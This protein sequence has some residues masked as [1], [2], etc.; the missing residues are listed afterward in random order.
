MACKLHA[1]QVKPPCTE[2]G[3][4]VLPFHFSCLRMSSLRFSFIRHSNRLYWILCHKISLLAWLSPGSLAETHD[5]LK[6]PQQMPMI[7]KMIKQCSKETAHWVSV[8]QAIMQLSTARQCSIVSYLCSNAYAPWMLV[9]QQQPLRPEP[10]VIW[11]VTLCCHVCG[12]THHVQWDYVQQGV[13]GCMKTIS[14]R[15]AGVLDTLACCPWDPDIC[16]LNHSR[17]GHCPLM[18]NCHQYGVV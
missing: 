9:V 3:F 15:Q 18:I 13:T 16:S 14:E 7:C 8:K 2:D 11:V 10:G 5:T 1:T 12:V 6:R 17:H 4:T